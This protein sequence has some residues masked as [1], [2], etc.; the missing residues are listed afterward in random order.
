MIPEVERESWSHPGIIGGR[1]YL[2]EQDNLFV[3]DLRA[4][5]QTKAPR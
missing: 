4:G 3:Y 2:R 5:A 1:L